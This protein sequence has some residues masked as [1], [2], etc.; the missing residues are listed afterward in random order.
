MAARKLTQEQAEEARRRYWE[1]RK[2]AW[3]DGDVPFKAERER[4]G[5]LTQRELAQEYGLGEA[6]MWKLLTGRSYTG[7]PRRRSARLAV[8]VEGNRYYT[9]EQRVAAV[10]L[11]AA[12]KTARSI[13]REYGISVCSLRAWC[14]EQG[15]EW[16]G[17]P[18]MKEAAE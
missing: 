16:R 11:Y 5:L 4:Y 18:R 13:Y 3:I 17:N 1:P 10:R 2:R 7:K 15:V 14:N 8:P 9:E 6:N 12:G